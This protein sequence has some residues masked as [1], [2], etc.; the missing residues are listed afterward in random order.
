M[1]RRPPRSTLFP[2]TTLFRS[3]TESRTPNSEPT[4]GN[5]KLFQRLDADFFEKDD[6][7]VAVILQ[8]D[9]ALVGAR[10]AL[11]FELEFAL[12]DGLAFGVVGDGDVIQNDDRARAIQGD[13]HGVPLGTG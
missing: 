5:S 10:A 3:Q 4:T 6:V 1:I 12:G 2:Y 9:V 11:W 7:I 8:T 13:D